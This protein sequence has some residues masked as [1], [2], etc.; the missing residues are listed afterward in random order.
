MRVV[1]SEQHRAD[2]PKTWVRVPSRTLMSNGPDSLF[3]F[4]YPILDKE[5][6]MLTVIWDQKSPVC[7]EHAMDFA[8]SIVDSDI[9][10]QN[11]SVHVSND[12]VLL[13]IRLRALQ[14][15]VADYVQVDINGSI[16]RCNRYGNV[17]NSGALIDIPFDIGMD[18]IRLQVKKR[19]QSIT[20]GNNA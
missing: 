6:D 3:F 9:V 5:I 19:K 4:A 14:L 13:A 10:L 16:H 11:K 7:D 8:N 12:C 15:D 17:K 1:E 18:L 2:A 20:R